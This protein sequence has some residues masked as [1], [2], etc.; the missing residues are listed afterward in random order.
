MTMSKRLTAKIASQRSVANELVLIPLQNEPNFDLKRGSSTLLCLSVRKCVMWRGQIMKASV[1]MPN[2]KIKPTPLLSEI[3]TTKIDAAMLSKR[4]QLTIMQRIGNLQ[5]KYLLSFSLI[6][7]APGHLL[8]QIF[9]RRYRIRRNTAIPP[10]R[11]YMPKSTKILEL[12][13]PC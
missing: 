6:F 9:A 10:K 3:L 1:A 11:R 7:Q 12:S 8:T 13:K 5:M 2:I 4:K